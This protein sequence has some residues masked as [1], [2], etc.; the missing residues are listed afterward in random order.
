MKF[1]N[2]FSRCILCLDN[3]ADSLEHIIPECIGGN[4]EINFLC[5]NCNNTK[6]SELVSKLKEDPSI[7]LAVRNLKNQIPGLFDQ[8]ENSQY[9]I[10]KDKDNNSIQMVY[11]NGSLKVKAHKKDDGSL[12]FDTQRGLK[13]IREMLKKDGLTE[14]EINNRLKIYQES[15]NEVDIQLSET[16]RVAK[17][18]LSEPFPSLLGLLINDRTLVLIAFEFLSLLIGDLIY[19]NR[20]NHIRDFINEGKENENILVERLGDRHYSPLHKIYSEFKGNEIVINIVLFRWL[21]FKVYFKNV[22]IEV[23]DRVYILDLTNGKS[24]FAKSIDD[25]RKGVFYSY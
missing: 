6:G 8:I 12:I 7:R 16:I 20:F 19:E 25:A 14:E 1:K 4:L 15:E 11:K 18:Q 5:T 17:K 9:Y 10:G 2:L 21:F 3:S 13:N 24:L 22:P 23:E